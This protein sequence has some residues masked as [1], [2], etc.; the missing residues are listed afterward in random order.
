MTPH[1][2]IL[3]THLARHAYIYVRQSTLRQVLYA[4]ESKERQY[5]LVERAATLGWPATQVVVIDD[6][7]GQSGSRAHDRNGFQE[8]MGAIAAPSSLR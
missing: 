7:Q 1:S 4:T 6:D 2:K 5:G 8:L 3:T